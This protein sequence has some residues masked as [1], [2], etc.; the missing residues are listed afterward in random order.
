[1]PAE[2]TA[3]PP[4]HDPSPGE[5]RPLAGYAV[6]LGAFS[7]MVGSFALWMR[8]SGR[9]LPERV[10]T[11]DLLLVTVATHKA[12]RLITKDRVTSVGRAPFTRYLRNGGPG[13]VEEAPR[14]RGLRH[15][16]GELLV[17][18]YCVGLWIA[19]ALSSGLLVSPRLTRWIA[20]VLAALFGSDV[21]HIVY[22]KAEESV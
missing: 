9:Q 4:V 19:V 7:T 14:G 6:L 18:P 1:M 8:V 22:K 15:A 10:E 5:E 17:C 21:L 20:S 16:I 13:E 11:R 2:R 3:A 12:S